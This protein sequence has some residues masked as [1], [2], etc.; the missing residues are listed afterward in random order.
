MGRSR[1]GGCGILRPCE[2][3]PAGVEDSLQKNK[4]FSRSNLPALYEVLE[5]NIKVRTV[6]ILKRNERGH[7]EIGR[8]VDPRL[9]ETLIKEL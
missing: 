5:Y 8:Y 7:D 9:A 4:R 1:R 6:V 3:S 2:R